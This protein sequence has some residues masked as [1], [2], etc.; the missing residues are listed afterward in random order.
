[1]SVHFTVRDFG[2]PWSILRMRRLLERSQWFTR[3]QM[4]EYQEEQLRGVIE[5]AYAHV[6]YYRH[7]FRSLSLTPAD[8]RTLADLRRLPL[9]SKDTVRKEFEQPAGGQRA[10]SPSKGRAHQRT[11]GEPLRFL[12]DKPSYVLEFAYYWRH[13]SWAEY[14][15]G[16]RFAELS[17]AHFLRRGAE[18]PVAV[19]HSRTIAAELPKSIRRPRA[20]SCIGDPQVSA[21]VSQRNTISA[22]LFRAVPA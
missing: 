12:L 2:H 10:A 3:E 18:Q 16:M 8:I 5:N 22:L 21:A 15:L 13:W 14:R 4:R 9:L 19:A 20:C 11:S 7:L 1:M 6:P 17:S